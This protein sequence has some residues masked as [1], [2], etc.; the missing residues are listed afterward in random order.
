[1]TVET[2]TG[3]D[4]PELLLPVPALE[5]VRVAVTGAGGFLGSRI[6]DLLAAHGADPVG[7]EPPDRCVLDPALLPDADWCLH[8]AAH[9]YATT[10]E[11][12]PAEVAD[13]NIRGTA[14]VVE[15]YGSRVVLASTCKAADAM[16]VYGASKLIAERVVLNA[17][18]RVVRFV[19]VLG[20]TGSVLE[21]WA[22]T[23]DDEPILI[24]ECERMWMTPAEAVRLMIAATAWPSGRYAIEVPAA[25]SVGALAR[26]VLDRDRVCMTIPP[27]RGDR[28]RERLVAESE[29]AV[30]IPE[31]MGVMRILHPADACA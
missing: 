23:P 6:M 13:L 3:L 20:S 12:M 25:E 1:M 5:G 15:R 10:A 11:D 17:G 24:A 9:K 29:I 4:R 14:N 18:G 16:T 8:L 22:D 31:A 26:R 21:L 19:N 2:V 28:V 7:C 27:R 30:P